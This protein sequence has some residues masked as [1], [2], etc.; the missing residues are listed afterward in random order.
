[1]LFEAALPVGRC[2]TLDSEGEARLTLAVPANFAKLLSD[3][4]HDLRDRSFAV[5]I[6]FTALDRHG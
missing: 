6:S 3:R 2:F 4:V 1:M 5:A